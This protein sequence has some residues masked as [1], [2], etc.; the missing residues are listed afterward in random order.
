MTISFDVINTGGDGLMIVRRGSVDAV[1]A[2]G[3]SRTFDGEAVALDFSLSA[4]DP[5]DLPEPPADDPPEPP[6][7]EP[8][9]GE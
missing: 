3:E 6:A 4:L 2:I 1:L 7:G 9:A 5:A 8:S